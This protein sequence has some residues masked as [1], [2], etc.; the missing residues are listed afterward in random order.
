MAAS[1][2]EAGL[3]P[4]G[5]AGRASPDAMAPAAPLFLDREPDGGFARDARSARDPQDLAGYRGDR[6]LHRRH[7]SRHDLDRAAVSR[8]S[9]SARRDQCHRRFADHPELRAADMRAEPG[10]HAPAPGH[11]RDGELRLS[12]GP[13]ADL[14]H[15]L[16]LFR[17]RGAPRAGHPGRRAGTAAEA[18]RPR[19]LSAADRARAAEP[20]CRRAGD[21][22][23]GGSHSRPVSPQARRCLASARHY[24]SRDDLRR[25]GARAAGRI[26]VHP[27]RH[28]LESRHPRHLVGNSPRARTADPTRLLPDGRAEDAVSGARGAREQ[29]PASAHDRGPGL[30][31]RRC[32]AG[33]PADLGPRRRRLAVEP[34]W[35]GGARPDRAYRDGRG[36]RPDRVGGGERDDRALSQRDRP[37]REHPP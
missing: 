35:R 10:G 27:A 12:L 14:R 31:L 1:R 28:A 29:V 25:V 37:R 36:D 6:R 7:L 3:H 34:A 22:R 17:H 16:R 23:R 21:T 18:S 33:V 11:G 32:G 26:R 8:P 24:L 19:G 20:P 13:A 30:H 2:R 15:R 9:R 4:R 5:R